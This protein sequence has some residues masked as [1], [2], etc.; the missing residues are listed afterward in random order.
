MH[1]CIIFRD[2]HYRQQAVWLLTLNDDNQIN[3]IN[4]CTIAPDP[5]TAVRLSP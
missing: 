5:Q 1:P 3:R 4:I 2:E